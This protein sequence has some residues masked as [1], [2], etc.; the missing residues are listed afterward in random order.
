MLQ[1]VLFL[2][3]T[4]SSIFRNVSCL[5]TLSF[6]IS[7]SLSFFN[8]HPFESSLESLFRFALR[9][10]DRVQSENAR[11][12]VYVV[13]HGPA[14]CIVS[15]FSP[16]VSIICDGGIISWRRDSILRPS[17]RMQKSC[18]LPQDHGVSAKMI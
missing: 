15:K 6:S 8:P 7:I 4:R 10:L 3:A 16:R 12:R 11:P 14:L 18:I 13:V 5:L 17:E 9:A 1:L 2:A